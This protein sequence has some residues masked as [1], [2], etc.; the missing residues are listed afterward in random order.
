[1]PIYRGSTAL[2]QLTVGAA[3]IAAVYYGAISI[4]SP[5]GTPAPDPIEISAASQPAIAIGSFRKLRAAYTGN[6]CQVRDSGNVLRVFPFGADGLID[7]SL[8]STYG[9]GVNF[10]FAGWYDQSGNARDL[11][12]TSR[13]IFRLDSIMTAGGKLLPGIDYTLKAQN[14]VTASAFLDVGGTSNL[15]VL[16]VA[17]TAGW[18][19][20]G[21]HARNPAVYS[22]ADGPLI[23][24]GTGANGLVFGAYKAA[25]ETV[26]YSKAGELYVEDG[27]P[28]AA[29]MR[30]IW[31]N[32][33]GAN[34]SGG[35]DGRKL[36]T[37]RPHGVA[38]SAANRLVLGNNG[39]VT[40]SHNGMIFEYAVFQSATPM[41]DDEIWA[42][43]LGQRN[44]WGTT[45]AANYPTRYYA[46]GVGQ[47]LIQY[48]ATVASA[49]TGLN[50]DNALN[51]VFIP[52]LR[53][54]L[55]TALHPE[56][57]IVAQFGATAYGGS[58]LLKGA[59]AGTP[60]GPGG[61]SW[62]TWDGATLT[63]K[64][65]WD[66][67]LDAPGP[68]LVNW[69]LQLTAFIGAKY[70]NTAL[71]WDQGQAEAITFTSGESGSITFANWKRCTPLV[72][73]EMRATLGNANIPVLI[74]P[75]GR[76][77]GQDT[78]MRTLRLAQNEFAA[79]DANVHI[80]AE[81]CDLSR[82]DTVH[83]AAGPAITDGFDEAARRLAQGFLAMFTPTRKYRGPHVA[84]AAVSGAISID[85]TCAWDSSGGGTYLTPASGI[86]GFV[87]T[88]GTGNRTINGVSA[89]EGGILRITVSDSALVAPVTVVYNPQVSN[90]DRTFMVKDNLGLPLAP[91]DVITAS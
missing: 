15:S 66:Q 61:T 5:G 71:L 13:P 80:G 82:Q 38:A 8:A 88:D 62:L 49:S 44:F 77:A 52:E 91:S 14:M 67:D 27:L 48:Y 72:W 18:S 85:V 33:T 16:M 11:S 7:T 69:K 81:D 42:L 22:N 90:L 17:Q 50:A 46:I 37:N 24:Y 51:R 60:D 36:F 32:Q 63:K 74:Q 56:R 89:V 57:E 26:M 40:Q 76:Q 21:T 73:A 55:A 10:T 58:S 41:T 64:F 79:N 47:S 25:G 70:A 1:M 34:V 31:F 59:G 54:K 20:A 29:R 28:T 12:S 68:V 6:C 53:T 3:V 9:D 43:A 39:A 19:S 86:L 65:W 75:L 87:V 45:A 23:G 83:L 84:S 4:F 30:N 35:A 2:A 78:W